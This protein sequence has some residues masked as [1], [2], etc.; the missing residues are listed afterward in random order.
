MR[1]DR[2]QGVSYPHTRV[3]KRVSYRGFMADFG[4][5]EA[6]FELRCR[7]AAAPH[8]GIDPHPWSGSRVDLQA[9]GKHRE[10][11]FE[12]PATPVRAVTGGAVEGANMVFGTLS[13]SERL[14]RPESAARRVLG[15]WPT[16]PKDGSERW[17]RFNFPRAD[18]CKNSA[19]GAENSGSQG[20]LHC[21]LGTLPTAQSGLLGG[22]ARP[23]R[24]QTEI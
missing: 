20:G 11:R 19:F 1:G 13:D 4:H 16:R 6:L 14:P 10:G 15:S 18:I 22:R 3:N 23:G 17:Q 8:C 12:A 9:G 5:F 7:H 21:A 2:G 24:L